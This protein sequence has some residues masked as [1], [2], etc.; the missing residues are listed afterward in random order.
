M[1]NT[2][3]RSRDPFVETSLALFLF[4]LSLLVYTEISPTVDDRMLDLSLEECTGCLPIET[5]IY[6]ERIATP[7][8]NVLGVF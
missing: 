6:D 2:K 1:Y 5:T 8:D 3:Y 7:P 4:I